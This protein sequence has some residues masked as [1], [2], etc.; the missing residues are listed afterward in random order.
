MAD[1]TA[2][3]RGTILE[4]DGSG[5]DATRTFNPAV[6]KVGDDYVMLYGGLPFA[7]NIEIGLATSDDGLTWTKASPL[8]VI[9]NGSSQSWASFREVPA[10]LLHEGGLYRLWFDGSNSN[11]VSDPG[12]GTGFGY[13]TSPDG[14]HWTW[15]P[16]N[17]VRWELNSPSGNGFD[18]REVVSFGGQYH[19]YFFDRNPGGDIL[20]HAT[21][22]DGMNFSGETPVGVASGYDL[23]AA[24]ADRRNRIRCV[25]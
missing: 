9:S 4:F 7:N 24:T 22:S 5:F 23:E 12:F 20:Y 2:T 15:D 19:A 13:A 25:E 11:L 18:L 21:S 17:P 14:T 10:T 3:L 1:I 16:D 6:T 8:P